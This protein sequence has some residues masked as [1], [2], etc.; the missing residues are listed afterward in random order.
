[1]ASQFILECS[2]KYFDRIVGDTLF[3]AM[4]PIKNSKGVYQIL[5]IKRWRTSSYILKTTDLSLGKHCHTN[6]DW[7]LLRPRLSSVEF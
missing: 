6:A 2:D 1:M 4:E 7:V 5:I 3:I